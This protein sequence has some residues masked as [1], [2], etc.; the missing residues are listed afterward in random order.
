MGR[1]VYSLQKYASESGLIVRDM[2]VSKAASRNNQALSNNVK[3]II[4]SM[5]LMGNYSSLGNFIVSLEKSSRI[6]DITN[7]SFSSAQ[8]STL[9]NFSVQVKT[10]SY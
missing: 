3:E 5:D 10:Y 9:G 8:G 7:I 6:F 2:A 1:L 4:F